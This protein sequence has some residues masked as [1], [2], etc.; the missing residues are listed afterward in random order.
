VLVSALVTHIADLRGPDSV[1]FARE[2]FEIA[3][4]TQANGGPRSM[5]RLDALVETRAAR[6]NGRSCEDRCRA[7]PDAATH[8]GGNV[9]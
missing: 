4:P 6:A 3:T 8:D 7:G 9:S 5:P 1:I 2:G